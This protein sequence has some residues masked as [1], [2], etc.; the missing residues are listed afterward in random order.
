MS[1]LTG[2][3]VEIGGAPAIAGLR[4]RR[5]RGEVDLP[6]MLDV[7]NSA[8]RADDLEEVATL[9]QLQINYRHL[10]N[11][12]PAR[13]MVVVEVDGR[14]V[15]YTRVLW[16][17]LN[18]GGRAYQLFGFIHPDW[19]RKRIGHALLRHNER[20]LR[21]I[22]G[23]HHDIAPKWFESGAADSDVGNARLLQSEGYT[24]ARY[25]YDMVR[26]DLDDIPDV[27][28]PDGIEIRPVSR[29]QY[30]AIWEADAEA[31][32]DHWGERDESEEA[33]RHFA[34]SP[35]NADPSLWQVAWDG[36]Q[37]AGLV[38]NTINEEENREFGRARGWLESVAVRR[39]WRRRGL[40]RALL[41]ASLGAMRGAGLTSAGLG[42]DT[43]NPLGALRLYESVGFVP[44]RRFTTYR[45]P[46]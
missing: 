16:S 10:R 37:I 35:D 20:R 12:D 13:D 44:D 26:H 34:E 14:T 11:C 18:E 24:P 41:A 22:A 2:E 31:F 4:F 46:L 43:E 28:L 15:G 7:Y 8:H 29:N 5:W 6:G 21:E 30:R 27:P 23:Q 36:D 42:V 32:R 40:A 33:F 3:T 38:I 9:E 17:E 45:K 25:F 1:A 19:R 39:P